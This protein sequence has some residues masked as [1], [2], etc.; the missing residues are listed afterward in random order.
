[1]FTLI[2]TGTLRQLLAVEGPALAISLLVAEMF[3]KFH[4]FVLECAGFLALW[5]ALGS[6]LWH[7]RAKRV[8]AKE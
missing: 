5:Y 7:V 6:I 2:K 1:M 8:G 4:S 3:F